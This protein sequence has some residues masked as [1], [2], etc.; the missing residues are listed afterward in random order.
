[1]DAVIGMMGRNAAG[2]GLARTKCIFGWRS[3][4]QINLTI[5]ANG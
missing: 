2:G 5:P 4:T 3:L 1:M